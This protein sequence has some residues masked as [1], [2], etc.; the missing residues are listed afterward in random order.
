MKEIAYA[1]FMGG[2]AYFMVGRWGADQ[3]LGMFVFIL[4][5]VGIS[6]SKL[7]KERIESLQNQV[8]KLKKQLGDR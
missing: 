3:A 4:A 8:D 7:H 5:F 6:A 1:L 2:C